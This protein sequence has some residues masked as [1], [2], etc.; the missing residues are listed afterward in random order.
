MSGY[1]ISARYLT[2]SKMQTL[3]HY[4]QSPR[5]CTAETPSQF[6]ITK[7]HRL[8]K[9]SRTATV[10][11]TGRAKEDV[12]KNKAPLPFLNVDRIVK[13]K[14]QM[15]N[16]NRDQCTTLSKA[17]STLVRKQSVLLLFFYINDTHT[18]SQN[19]ILYRLKLSFHVVA[20]AHTL[21]I[22]YQR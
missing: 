12:F 17:K 5:M 13:I 6:T 11:E 1:R 10:L 2:Q 22:S 16:G 21:F 9:I 18:I 8:A 3:H 14:V 4:F 20:L 15:L 7:R 19:R